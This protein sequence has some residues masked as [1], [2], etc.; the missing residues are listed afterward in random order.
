LGSDRFDSQCLLTT[1]FS[2]DMKLPHR[3][4]HPDL[5]SLGSRMRVRLTLEPH[6]KSDLLQYLEH[7]L[8]QAGAPT[9]MTEQLKQTLI[10]H[11]SGNLRLLNSM[12]AELLDK[13]AHQKLQHLDEQLFIKTFSPR[14]PSRN[15]R[16]PPKDQN[17]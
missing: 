3:F 6:D 12:A 11:S 1:V 8:E 13:A 7:C 15:R 14:P 5:V 9:L 4:R 2:S 16:K 17:E 10:E